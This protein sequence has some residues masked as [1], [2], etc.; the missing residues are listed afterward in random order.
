MATSRIGVTGYDHGAQY[1]TA[2]G[3]LFSSYIK[4]ME[5]TGYAARWLPVAMK[6]G[7]KGAGQMHPWYVGTPGMSAICRPLAESVRIHTGRRAHTLQRADR[8]WQIWFDDETYV[9]PFAAVAVATPAPQ[10]QLILGP[11]DKLAEPLS[12]VRM[13]PCWALTV[14]LDQQFLTEQ[15]VYSDMSD[16]IRWVSRNNS[17][18]GRSARGDVV[19]IH[20]SQAW[21]REAEDADPDAVAEELWNEVSHLLRLPPIRPVA[22]TAHLWRHGLVDHSLGETYVYSSEHHVGVCGDWCLGRLG[23]HAFESGVGLGRAIVNSLI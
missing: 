8:G 18:P 4:E 21:S 23:E 14:V 2:R 20:A 22:M 9:G 5:A 13:S 7:E 19:V 11:L 17:K 1:L 10:A 16:V 12:R 15:D 3:N 6:G